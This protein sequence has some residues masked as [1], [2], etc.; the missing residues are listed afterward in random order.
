MLFNKLL[1]PYTIIIYL[2]C[3][4]ICNAHGVCVALKLCTHMYVKSK[5]DEKQQ[6]AG[7]AYSA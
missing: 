3:L 2:L 4:T 5:S 1:S 7:L 6:K